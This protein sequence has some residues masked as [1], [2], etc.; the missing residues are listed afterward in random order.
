MAKS[1]H[2]CLTGQKTKTNKIIK[3]T[4]LKE[5]VPESSSVRCM[6]VLRELGVT[7]QPYLM[8]CCGIEE[9]KKKKDRKS[10]FSIVFHYKRNICETD[11][12]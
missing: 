5:C 2:Q 10:I 12:W 1:Q 11:Y 3:T 9:K 7:S 4:L 6:D 8:A